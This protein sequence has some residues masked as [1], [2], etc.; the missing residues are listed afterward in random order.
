MCI[1]SQYLIKTLKFWAFNDLRK[2]WKQFRKKGKNAKKNE[3][4][5]A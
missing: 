2:A 3:E 4:T 1:L 5:E